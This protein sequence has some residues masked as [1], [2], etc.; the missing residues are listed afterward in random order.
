MMEK[1]CPFNFKD[2]QFSL[3]KKKYTLKL[4]RF[5]VLLELEQKKV[6]SSILRTGARFLS[7]QEQKNLVSSLFRFPIIF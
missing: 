6:P 7:K 2:R 5:L 3:E 1:I 4:E